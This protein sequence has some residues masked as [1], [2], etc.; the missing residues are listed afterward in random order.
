MKL[1]ISTP[2]FVTI[3]LLLSTRAT[4]MCPQ[5][6]GNTAHT[7]NIAY[8]TIAHIVQQQAP[9]E[10]MASSLPIVNEWI[11]SC[12]M[13]T[14]ISNN[15]NNAADFMTLKSNAH[16]LVGTL[17]TH[18]NALDKAIFISETCQLVAAICSE[19]PA[20]FPLGQITDQASGQ[21]HLANF[22]QTLTPKITTLK[23]IQ[24]QIALSTEKL[25]QWLSLN[26]KKS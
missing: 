24:S 1:S 10:S 6:K 11:C 20:Q 3:L 9:D 2:L 22:A 4:A 17:M 16:H 7:C 18:L 21:A 23:Q 5:E 12:I 14:P 19:D 13:I 26:A 25:N 15:N 8:N